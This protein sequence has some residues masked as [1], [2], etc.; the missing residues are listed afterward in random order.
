MNDCFDVA[1]LDETETVEKIM[2]KRGSINFFLKLHRVSSIGTWENQIAC[3]IMTK[4]K[5][6]IDEQQTKFN[7]ML[8]K[9]S[10]LLYIFL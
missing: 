2:E 7:L 9:K 10:K 5:E 4:Y 1:S 6:Y 3:I 8:L